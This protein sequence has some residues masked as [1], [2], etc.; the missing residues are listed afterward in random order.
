MTKWIRVTDENGAPIYIRAS[1]VTMLQ[2]LRCEDGSPSPFGRN[3]RI[4]LVDRNTLC[5]PERIEDVAKMLGWEPI[6]G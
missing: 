1:A 5:V 2:V 3:T 6:K 4:D